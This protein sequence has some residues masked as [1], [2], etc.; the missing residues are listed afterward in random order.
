MDEDIKMTADMY[1]LVAWVQ[2]QRK[3]LIVIATAVAAVALIVVIYIWH[4]NANETLAAE[5]LSKLKPSSASPDSPASAAD[6]YLRL[7]NDFSGT[8]AAGRALLVAGGIF[9]DA[10]KYSDAQKQ[11]GRFLQEYPDSPLANQAAVGVAASLEASTNIA[12]ATSRYSELLS[13]HPNDSTTPQVK[14]ALAR[15]YVAQNK[16]DK[17]FELYAQLAQANNPDSWSSEAGIQAE[18]LLHKYPALRKAIAPPPSA[19]APMPTLDFQKK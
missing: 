6:P 1:R 9:F 10:G 11:F 16:P 4:T 13:R 17:A 19:T 5:T 3:P 2:A 8:R 18:E 7:V 14:S 15:L 12:E